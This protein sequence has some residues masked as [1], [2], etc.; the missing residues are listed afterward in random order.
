MFAANVAGN[1]Q[2][3]EQDMAECTETP[4][5]DKAKYSGSLLSELTGLVSHKRYIIEPW[6]PKP[7][8]GML[9]GTLPKGIKITDSYTG[10]CECVNIFRSQHM[11]KQ[12]AFRRLGVNSQNEQKKRCG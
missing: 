9:T 3:G 4:H 8:K 1:R 2:Q 11:N 5:H 7:T 12:E 6:P 10:T